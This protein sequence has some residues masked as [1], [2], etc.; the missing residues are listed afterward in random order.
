MFPGDTSSWASSRNP[1]VH[2]GRRHIGAMV[3]GHGVVVGFPP[4]GAGP[5]APWTP[6]HPTSGTWPVAV[7][8]PGAL[9]SWGSPLPALLWAS[10]AVD[11]SLP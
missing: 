8:S 5:L 7:G 9:A 10:H 2:Q 1:P 4:A 3:W 11:P 6:S